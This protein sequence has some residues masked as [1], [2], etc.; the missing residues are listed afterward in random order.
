LH[1]LH[2]A[3]GIKLIISSFHRFTL[4]K[5]REFHEIRLDFMKSSR[6]S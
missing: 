6:I 5:S 4:P 1:A 2:D 3:P